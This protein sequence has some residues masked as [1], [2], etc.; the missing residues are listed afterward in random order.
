MPSSRLVLF[1]TNETKIL[2][3]NDM[4]WSGTLRTQKSQKFGLALLN[5][6]IQNNQKD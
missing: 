2:T 3:E 6:I 4:V 1:S 5:Q